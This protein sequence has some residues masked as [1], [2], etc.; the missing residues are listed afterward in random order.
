MISSLSWA[1]VSVSYLPSPTINGYPANSARALFPPLLGLPTT[2]DSSIL[3]SRPQYFRALWM[4]LDWN[5]PAQNCRDTTVTRM[6]ASS[7]C[8]SKL[9]RN[10]KQVNRLVHQNARYSPPRLWSHALH[11]NNYVLM[12][13]GGARI[14]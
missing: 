6:F 9:F 13:V 10:S 7:I 3:C 12:S 11:Q 8:P 14:L 5:A 2:C 1:L 4:L